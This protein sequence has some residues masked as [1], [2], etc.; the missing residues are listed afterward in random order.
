M[1]VVKE[2]ARFRYTRLANPA[3]ETDDGS[4][5]VEGLGR[6]RKSVPVR[7]FYDDRGSELFEKICELPEYYLTRAERSILESCA[8]EI[9]ALTGPCEL[10]ELGSGSARK[11]RLLLEAHARNDQPLRFLPIDVSEGVLKASARD[12]LR[13]YQDLHIHGFSGTYEQALAALPRRKAPARMIMFLG[14][15][16]GNFDPGQCDVFL[17]RLTAAMMPGEYFL[18]GV[19][20]EKDKDVLEAAYND[21]QGIT[22]AFNLNMLRHLNRR[23]NGNFVLDEFAHEAFYNTDLSQIEMHLRS[24]RPQTVTLEGLELEVSFETGETI[25]TE[26]S[27]KFD[28]A[29]LAAEC[30]AK[31]LE[32]VRAWSDAPNWFALLLF[33]LEASPSRA[34]EGGR[35]GSPGSREA[36]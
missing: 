25:Q 34:D 15:T 21:S 36:P 29:A 30:E 14:S 18:L 31:G 32:T 27:R 33:R 17:D 2:A 28:S 11:T 12:L 16:L 35:V 19:D 5:V 7:Y 23:F 10:V 22:A 26:I 9:A 6:T 24:R 3:H 20:L 1:R 13:R 4:D 8:P